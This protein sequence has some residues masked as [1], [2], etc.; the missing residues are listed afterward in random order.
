[1]RFYT[2]ESKVDRLASWH[3]HFAWLPVFD[4]HIA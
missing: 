4:D 2:T 3:M 1:M